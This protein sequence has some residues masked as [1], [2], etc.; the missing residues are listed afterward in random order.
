MLTFLAFTYILLLITQRLFGF[1]S[2][3]I[4]LNEA[5]QK[6]VI[7]DP[8][9]EAQQEIFGTG[10]DDTIN[11]MIYRILSSINDKWLNGSEN[12]S[13][14]SQCG[15]TTKNEIDLKHAKKFRASATEASLI[16]TFRFVDRAFA[17]IGDK[18]SYDAN[19]KADSLS[20]PVTLPG[21]YKWDTP[22]ALYTLGK[23]ALQTRDYVKA[24]NKFF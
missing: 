12:K 5:Y 3:L 4:T 10:D 2:K 15:E 17:D 7:P 23:G 20:R 24:E 8:E 19:P 6:E 21:D 9:D 11:L 22:Y 14:F 18:F 1:Y 13:A 16:D